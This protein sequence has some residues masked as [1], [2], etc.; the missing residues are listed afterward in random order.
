MQLCYHSY[1]NKK[2]KLP[3]HNHE[4]LIK[5]TE[6]GHGKYDLGNHWFDGTWYG[7]IISMNTKGFL[8]VV[9]LVKLQEGMAMDNFKR[10]FWRE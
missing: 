6:I 7:S 1:T 5:T 8:L 3:E 9:F 4:N 2:Q 10:A